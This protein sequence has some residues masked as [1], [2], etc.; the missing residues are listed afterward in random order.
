MG[1]GGGKPLNIFRLGS[2]L[3]DEPKE[4]LNWRLWFAVVSFGIM[5]A[6]RGVDEGLISGTFNTEDFQQLL[7]FDK[8][9]KDQYANVKGNVSA[10]VQIGSV[11]GALLAFVLA[12]R[13]GR[14]WATRQLCVLWI[15]G[16][17]IFMTNNGRL[18]QVYAGRFIAGLGIGQTT[19]IAPVYLS[20][21]SPKAVRGLC[22]CVFSGSVYIGIMLAYFSTWG[23]SLHIDQNKPSSW[24]VPTSLHLIFASL[25]FI[26]SWFNNE[27]PRFLIKQGKIDH[28]TGNLA[29]IRGLPADDEYV[30]AEIC[31][32]VHQLNEEQEATMGQ[33]FWGILREIF[34]MPDN[35]YRIY[36][37]LGV[38]LLGQWSGAQ[39][40]TIYAPDMFALLGTKGNNE[41]LYATAIFGVV[42]FVSAIFCALFLVDAIGRK[43]SLSIGI[44]LQAISMCYIAAFLTAVPNI[45]SNTVFTASQKH[46]STGGI[47]MIY[48]SGV[49]WALGFNSIQYLL[50]AEIY[51][52]RIRAVCS[53]LVMCFHFVNQYG[54]S[55]AVPN[56]LLNLSPKGTFW[57]F[58]G[59]TILGGLWAWLFIPETSGRSLEGMDALFRLPWYKIGRYGRREADANDQLTRERVLEE[60]AAMGGNAAMVEVVQ[61]EKVD[62]SRSDYYLQWGPFEPLPI[63][64]FVN[65]GLPGKRSCDTL[66]YNSTVG[67]QKSFFLDDDI[68]QIA[69]TLDSHPMVDYPDEMMNDPEMEANEIIDKT[70]ARLSGSSV[71]LPEQK[72]FL[73]VTR[74]IF[75]PSKTRS[76]PKMS[77]LRGQLYNQDWE[78]LDNHTIAWDGQEF[79]FPLVFDIPVQWEE[80]GSLYGPEDPR[81]ILEDNVEGAEPVVIFNMIAK[82]TEWKRAMYIF[83][84]FSNYSTILTIKD[85]DRQHTEKN[86]APFFIPNE[87]KHKATGKNPSKAVAPVRQSS[88][89]IRFVYSFKPLRIL[90]CHLRCGDCEFEFE[91]EVPDN[92]M[93]KHNEDGGSLRGGTNFVP[94]PLPSSMDIDPRVRVYAAFPRTNIEKQC[95]GSFYRPEFVVMINIGTQFHLAFASESLDF[96]TSL[97]D[98]GPEDDRCDKGRILIP[99]SVA[100]WDTSNGHDVMSVTFSV[101][102]ETVQVARVQGLLSFVRNL[103]Q[104]KTLL[105]KDGLLKGAD[106]D[107]MS[108]LSS[109][110]GDDVRGCLVEAALKYAAA[111]KE[112][113]LPKEGSEVMEVTK[114]LMQKLKL[115]S[116]T[117]KQKDEEIFN[118]GFEP[119]HMFLEHP[120]DD[121]GDPQPFRFE[122]LGEFSDVEGLSVEGLD[123]GESKDEDKQGSPG[124]EEPK[125]DDG[126][127]EDTKKED[128]KNNGSKEDER[129]DE[130]QEDETRDGMKSD[131]DDVPEP[132]KVNIEHPD[133]ETQDTREGDKKDEG[134]P[135][136]DNTQTEPKP[137]HAHH[138]YHNHQNRRRRWS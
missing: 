116:D 56:M 11:G 38:Q 73:S 111:A 103:P 7:G 6:A 22:T 112:I 39:S 108:T 127:R 25:I 29:K 131:K 93:T 27:S 53:S 104:F 90:K 68:K 44:A 70:W 48:I 41:K 114:E 24:M 63:P 76:V 42:K 50:N 83:R 128:E 117:A 66:K 64:G 18:G 15:L 34:C 138:R 36:L 102:D 106:P 17:V 10:M 107:L 54:N 132:E 59:I 130:T 81:I 77:F 137:Q 26:L 20:E 46:A 23:S 21:I 19:V 110:V 129:K 32:I 5:G 60:K 126:T 35:F 43:R 74:V 16:I 79:T 9:D 119:G 49:G 122:M 97:L 3:A 72:V 109:W 14:L 69:M 118:H 105:K 67:V 62:R 100:Q 75:C 82:R 98:L 78:H 92:F 33:G 2:S 28:A 45:D 88:E 124:K 86:W 85:A 87:Q 94:V 121:D 65:T 12:D 115:E 57:F 55:R 134:K 47:V 120:L 1:G 31:G 8:L 95:D 89:Y 30:T 123:G 136:Q 52:L 113:S 71:W 80:E 96:G 40:I 58:T 51:P 4:V 91:Q 37:G 84:P 99:N 13:I 135:P 61:Q 133:D 125:K 101:N